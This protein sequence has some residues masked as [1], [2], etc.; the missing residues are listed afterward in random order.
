M[1]YSQ[2]AADIG[3]G[4]LSLNQANVA[5]RDKYGADAPAKI[6]NDF[7]GKVGGNDAHFYNRVMAG[8]FDG[9]YAAGTL[10]VS[11]S[12]EAGS[13]TPAFTFDWAGAE[14]A[15][16]E[17]LTP[18]YDQKL[19]ETGGDVERAKKLIEADY[20]SG[21]RY[22]EEDAKR[23]GQYR[24][25]DLASALKEFGFESA[26]ELRQT[27]G[28]LNER[29][30][31]LGEIAQGQP[32]VSRAPESDYARMYALAPLEER[33]ALRKQA[34]ERAITRQGDIAKTD[35]ARQQEQ[36]KLAKERG[37]EEQ[38]IQY[39]RITTTLAQEKEEKAKLQLAPQAYQQAL[40]EYRSVNK[41]PS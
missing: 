27:R 6:V 7:V 25:E 38:D 36:L 40:T 14:K 34:I 15:A 32:G 1:P 31:L 23:G 3:K 19:K 29:N 30:V 20:T 11:P 35:T 17:K 16:L 28:A 4:N 41:I 37:I 26:E 2:Y 10:G 13:A 21:L 9:E 12:P 39:P 18:Y 24:T 33:Q 8:D 5:W 22:S